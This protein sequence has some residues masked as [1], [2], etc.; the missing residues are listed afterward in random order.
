MADH[1][2][3]KRDSSGNLEN[4]GT[5]ELDD[6]QARKVVW[7]IEDS[8]IES[9]RIVAKDGN[10]TLFLFKSQPTSSF[11]TKDELKVKFLSG[12]KGEWSY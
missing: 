6:F 12:E 4:P 9:L 2:K 7:E 10:G 1:I 11:G 8:R 3:L 5:P